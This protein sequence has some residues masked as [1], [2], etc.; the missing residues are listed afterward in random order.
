MKIYTTLLLAIYLTALCS[1]GVHAQTNSSFENTYTIGPG[2]RIQIIVYDEDDLSFDEILIN[3]S[4]M[5]DFPYLGEIQVKGKT[6][7]Q[8]KKLID[9][10]LRGDYL[11][12]PKVMVNFIAFREIY[13]NGEVK[14]PG[15]YPYQPG[16]TVDKAIALAGGF[17]DR[18]SR[19]KVQ[20]TPSGRK[21]GQQRSA[22][23]DEK[24]NPG[25]I[26]V[27]NQSLF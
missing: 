24:V 7:Q 20:L 8:L 11:I 22:S 23:L 1:T 12:N 9:T 10:G 4:G 13:V 17:T 25:D 14:R 6:S 16:L 26:I 21:D 18:A 27:I 15:G 19:K 5:F 3:S 2:D